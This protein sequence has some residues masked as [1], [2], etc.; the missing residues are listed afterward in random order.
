MWYNNNYV[1][2]PVKYTQV[3]GWKNAW[4]YKGYYK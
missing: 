1:K 3:K 4:K 2:K